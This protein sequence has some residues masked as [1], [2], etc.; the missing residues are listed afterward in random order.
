MALESTISFKIELR[1]QDILT[2]VVMIP[3]STALFVYKNAINYGT[4]FR[5]QLNITQYL[6]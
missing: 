4:E 6:S 1:T 2:I 5:M 3:D